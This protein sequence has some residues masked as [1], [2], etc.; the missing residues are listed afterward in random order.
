MV[1]QRPGLLRAHKDC[2]STC[3]ATVEA[4]PWWK[5][6]CSS[7][8]TPPPPPC[9]LLMGLYLEPLDTDAVV[10]SLWYSRLYLCSEAGPGQETKGHVRCLRPAW[11]LLY[12]YVCVRASNRYCAICM[13]NGS[14]RAKKLWYKDALQTSLTAVHNI[15]GSHQSFSAH[16]FY[17]A[18]RINT[19]SAI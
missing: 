8:E 7:S 12:V 3:I 11:R 19:W 10:F 14:R 15:T 5:W 4:R 6:E 1:N 17:V 2:R 13:V 18:A 16:S 9:R